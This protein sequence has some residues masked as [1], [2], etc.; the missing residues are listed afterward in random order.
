MSIHKKSKFC[1]PYA[2]VAQKHNPK[3]AQMALAFVNSRSFV[4]ANI[5]GATTIE[6][7]ARNI[8]SA[9]LVLSNDVLADI[10]AVQTQYPNPAP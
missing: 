8:A 2:E 9:D 5:I 10:E 7:L 1:K 6:Q 4:T 3:M